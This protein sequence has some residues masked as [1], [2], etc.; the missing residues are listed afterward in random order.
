MVVIYVG[1]ELIRST[2]WCSPS[3]LLRQAGYL[4]IGDPNGGDSFSHPGA[5]Q[6]ALRICALGA[7]RLTLRLQPRAQDKASYELPPGQIAANSCK[8][9]T[10]IV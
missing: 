10:H 1:G 9:F 4:R 2:P 5:R 6:L 3:C 7:R 8:T